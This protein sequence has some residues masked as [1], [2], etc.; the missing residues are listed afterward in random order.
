MLMIFLN[1]KITFLVPIDGSKFSIKAAD[2]AMLLS[3]KLDA[4]LLV[5]HVLDDIPYEHNVG[6]FG[7]YDIE[8]PDEIK[9]ILQEA[10]DATREWFD[11]I[12]TRAKDSRDKNRFS[13][14]EVIN[15]VGYSKLW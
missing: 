10:R 3:S 4:D 1:T 13:H 11:D 5:I 15:R 8:T 9:Q 12:K 6:A 14:H 2:Y 7:L